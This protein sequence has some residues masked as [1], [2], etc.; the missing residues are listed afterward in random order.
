MDIFC[1]SLIQEQ[2]TLEEALG[3]WP[4]KFWAIFF[5]LSLVLTKY[6]EFSS[7]ILHSK[8][9]WLL[10]KDMVQ[11]EEYRIERGEISGEFLTFD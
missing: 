7:L 3:H 11:G 10:F 8:Y 4:G 6:F 9:L 1:Y 5:L 2:G